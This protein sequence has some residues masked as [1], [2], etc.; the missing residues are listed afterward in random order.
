MAFNP[1]NAKFYF[2]EQNSDGPASYI[3]WKEP[4]VVGQPLILQIEIVPGVSTAIV[5]KNSCYSTT[6]KVVSVN[7]SEKPIG[8]KVVEKKTEPEIARK[9]KT[10][11]TSDVGRFLDLE[12]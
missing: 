5:G 10:V 1:L 11:Q 9:E 2:V 7:I 3:A 4:P 8:K 12:N 6:V